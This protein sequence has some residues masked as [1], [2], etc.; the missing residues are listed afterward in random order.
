MSVIILAS[1][2]GVSG[3]VAELGAKLKETIVRPATPNEGGLDIIE[4][5]EGEVIEET[6]ALGDHEHEPLCLVRARHFHG[7][8]REDC[9]RIIEESAP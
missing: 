8:V 1:L 2:F 9:Q 7:L 3:C 6:P 4:T 5:P